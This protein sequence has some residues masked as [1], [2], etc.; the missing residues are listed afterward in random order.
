MTL[1]AVFIAMLIITGAFSNLLKV[2]YTTNAYP[3]SEANA[4]VA[5]F[6]AY[7]SV[8]N[9][10]SIFAPANLD[11]ILY[12]VTG[13]V[14]YT[15]ETSF[16]GAL[17]SNASDFSSFLFTLKYLNVSYA[18]ISKS[19]NSVSQFLQ[20]YPLVYSTNHYLVYHVTEFAPVGF[21]SNNR[22]R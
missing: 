5:D 18:I 8:P 3:I 12:S 15:P 7:Q 1:C 10:S 20:Y 16:Y 11:T 6:M 17:L 9:G 4:E 13:A 22:F 19:D 2:E 21:L 14:V